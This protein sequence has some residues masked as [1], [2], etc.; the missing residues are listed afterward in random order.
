MRRPDSDRDRRRRRSCSCSAFRSR[1]IKL[2]RLHHAVAAAERS[3]SRQVDEIVRTR[4]RDRS[5]PVGLCGRQRSAGARPSVRGLRARRLGSLPGRPNVA[6][7]GPRRNREPG[8]IDVGTRAGGTRTAGQ[9]LVADMRAAA[10]EISGARRRRDAPR[11]ST[12]SRACSQPPVRARHP[13]RVD[14]PRALPDDR[15]VL[16]PLKAIVLNLLTITAVFGVLVWIFQ[17]G[18]LE[19]C[20]A[21]RARAASSRCTRSSSPRSPS[22]SRPTT[23][24]SCSAGSKRPATAASTTETAVAFGL[25][26]TGGSCRPRRCSSSSRSARSAPRGSSSIKE[27]GLGTG[28]AVLLDATIV[29][30][31]LVPSLM[32]L[33]GRWN[34][35]APALRPALARIRR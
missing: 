5:E 31:L 28:L 1:G 6:T 14:A 16:L 32:C 25:E 19:G 2:H 4:V 11:S 18:R 29:R 15:S 35:W 26:R 30:A 20:S 3:S 22:R 27:V 7:A 24:S 23:G 17:D 34:W 12:R 21:T 33:F 10:V 13:R 8:G 9:R